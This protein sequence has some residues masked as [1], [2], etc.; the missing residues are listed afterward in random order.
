MRRVIRADRLFDGTGAAPIERA[1]VVVEDGRVL[2]VGRAGEV[3]EAQGDSEAVSYDGCTIIPGLI[4]GHV[5]LVFTAGAAPL[6]DLLA[7]DDRQLLLTAVHNAQTALRVGVTTVKD[8]GGRGG[9]TLVLRDAIASGVLPGARILAAG[10]PITSTG[11][12]C[13]WLGGEADT[14]DD[15]RRRV[16]ELVRSGVDLIKVM[17][18]G[19]RMTAGSNVCAAQ[20]TVEQLGALVEDGRRL[21]RTV[22][23]HAQGTAGIRNA[24]AAGVNVVEH[25]TWVSTRAGN[26]VEYDE[27]A[28]EEMARK[29]IFMDPTLS[30]GSTMSNRDP[31]TLTPSQRETRAIRPRVIEAH[32]R[33]VELGVEIAA[34][35]D[36]GVAN[37]P[38]DRMP[39]EV[40]L[41][42]ELVGLSPAEAIRAATFNG[43]R[44]AKLDDELGSIRPGRRAD[45]LIVRGNPLEDL[46]ALDVVRAVYKD[47][48]LEVENGRLVRT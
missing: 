30:P 20:F 35:T 33:S 19:G 16:R 1:V 6:K 3:D 17:S 4:D 37:I 36:A 47:G 14:A 48:V 22:A 18:T 39:N 27:R 41:L 10:P 26:E 43:A 13:H 28:V 23:A 2:A 45:L 15:L 11:G 8:L 24:V 25:C 5:H 40:R 7:S 29:G 32:R 38:L 12:H 9:V 46:R 21:N 34:G 42:H 31:A 44:A